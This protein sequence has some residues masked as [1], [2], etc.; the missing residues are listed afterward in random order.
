MSRNSVFFHDFGQI[1]DEY[2]IKKIVVFP[3][4]LLKKNNNLKKKKICF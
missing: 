1:S 4:M 3:D 2:T